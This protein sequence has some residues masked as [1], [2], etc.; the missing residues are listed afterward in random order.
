MT[1]KLYIG[2]AEDCDTVRVAVDYVMNF[3]LPPRNPSGELLISQETYLS[4][5]AAWWLMTLAQRDEIAAN[6]VAPWVNW[7]LQFSALET[8]SSPGTRKGCWIPGDIPDL[9]Q[10]ASA[11][12]RTLSIA[13]TLALN[14]AFLVGISNYPANW[15]EPP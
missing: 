10:A 3:P 5:H 15:T 1:D 8:E 14:A 4:L 6:P 13:Q 9:I 2:T 11:A 12:G 7:T